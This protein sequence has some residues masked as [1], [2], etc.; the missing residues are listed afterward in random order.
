MPTQPPRFKTPQGRA[1]YFAAYDATLAQWPVPVASFDVPTRFGRMHVNACGPQDAPPLLLLPGQAISSTMWYPNACALSR[2]HR[3]FALDIIGDL[4]KS[5]SS[6]PRLSPLEYGAWLIEVMDELRIERAHVAGLSFGGYLALR[7]ALSAPERVRKLVLMA[8]AGLLPIRLSFFLRMGA[9]LLP[10]F[11]MSL[12]AK[13]KWL[14]G[15]YSPN[16]IPAFQ[17]M[18]T[19]ADFRYQM[20]LPP[21]CTD[22]ELAQVQSPTLLLF[23]DHEVVYDWQAARSRAAN[24]IAQV[25]IEVIP[26]AGHALNFDRHEMVNRYLLDFLNEDSG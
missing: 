22:E 5:V 9:V 18:M 26:G 16:L 3:L 10:A 20:F 4:G 15:M 8:P 21:V 12:K 11:V 7:L 24:L 17:Q 1:R 13:Q 23:G 6:R 14:L 25:E 19:S 2:A